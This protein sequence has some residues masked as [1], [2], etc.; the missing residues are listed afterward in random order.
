MDAAVQAAAETA[1]GFRP[2]DEGLALH[3]AGLEVILDVV[4][5]HTAEG[6][7][8][9][10]TLAFRGI[11]NAAYYRLGDDRRRMADFTGCG[12]SLDLRNPRVLQPVV[13]SLRRFGLTGD[14]VA[15]D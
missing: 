1:R 12:H 11:D 10:P 5:N 8:R 9:G 7:E 15:G 13:D 6:S 3:E 4:Y 2:P 14:Q